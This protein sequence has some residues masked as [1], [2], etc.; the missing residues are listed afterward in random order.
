MVPIS[1]WIKKKRERER[2]RE[3]KKKQ[4]RLVVKNNFNQAA[5]LASGGTHEKLWKEKKSTPS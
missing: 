4:V 3:A 1:I 5:I 2:E